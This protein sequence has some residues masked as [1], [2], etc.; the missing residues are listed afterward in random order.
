[1]PVMKLKDIVRSR[2]FLICLAA[3]IVV[4][5]AYAYYKLFYVGRF[6]VIQKGVLYRSQQPRGLQWG[7]LKR[8]RIKTVVDLRSREQ[9]PAD[10]DEEQRVCAEAGVRF[11][12]IPVEDL[13]PSEEQVEQ[14][15][16]AVA[17]G[18]PV[19]VHCELGRNR[20]GFMVAAYR[21]VFQDWSVQSAVEEMEKYGADV[22]GQKG[23][24]TRQILTKLREHRQE[25]LRR[26][27]PLL[28]SV[29]RPGGTIPASDPATRR[30]T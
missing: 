28:P 25:W 16:M 14:F 8:H 20:T 11:V 10:F 13:L 1:M 2:L 27:D 12:S 15:L 29:P 24:L 23:E 7:V 5:A 18:P 3:V 26:V 17:G 30:S 4:G 9:G 6:Y 21:V 19:L 22:K